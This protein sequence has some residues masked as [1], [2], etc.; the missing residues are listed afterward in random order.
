M[1]NKLPPDSLE[2]KRQVRKLLEVVRDLLKDTKNT[3][4]TNPYL[5]RSEE[6]MVHSTQRIAEMMDKD[7]NRYNKHCM[8]VLDKKC[9][10]VMG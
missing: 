2:N 9:I 5:L 6:I 4:F 1:N 7:A 3:H 10:Y 8:Y